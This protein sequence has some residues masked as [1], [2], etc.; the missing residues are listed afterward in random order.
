LLDIG[1]YDGLFLKEAQRRGWRGYGVEPHKG[2]AAF[3]RETLGL[4]VHTG[5]LDENAF[6][7]LTFDVVCMLS[8]LEHTPNP[9][10]V[11]REIRKRITPDGV[12]LLV[13]PTVPFYLRLVRSRW[14]MFIGEHYYFF[15]DRSMG[16]LLAEAGFTVATVT[17]VAKSVDLE[18]ILARLRDPWQPYRIGR[19]GNYLATMLDRPLLRKLRFRIN[20]FD[21]TEYIARPS[22]ALH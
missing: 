2:G 11:L 17:R 9:L 22:E 6:P 8:V 19:L 13:V 15:T 14:R 3:A 1:F 21:V 7:G 5:L 20:L 18:T 12:L 10:L 16:L 4:S